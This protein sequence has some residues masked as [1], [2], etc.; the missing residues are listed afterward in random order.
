MPSTD[1]FR[2]TLKGLVV[3]ME[4][5]WHAIEKLYVCPIA[6]GVDHP[7]ATKLTTPDQGS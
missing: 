3:I 2:G 4:R 5:D 7:F 6:L 1:C